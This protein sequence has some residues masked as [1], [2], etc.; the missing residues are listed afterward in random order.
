[1]AD[2]SFGQFLSNVLKTASL[3]VLKVALP[4]IAQSAANLQANPSVLN[5]QAQKLV[6]MGNLI[7]AGTQLESTVIK[8]E[9]TLI[10]TDVA[11]FEAQL[12][13]SLS[14]AAPGATPAT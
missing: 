1:M 7:G 13:K 4:V 9:L 5:L 8:D 11:A 3:D 2:T 12:A 6:I 10:S 14:P